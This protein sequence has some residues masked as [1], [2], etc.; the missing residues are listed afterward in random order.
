[1]SKEFTWEEVSRHDKE[2]D[3]WVVIDSYVYDVSSFVE[4]HPG[5]KQ[6]LKN[7]CG[8]D[9]T[10]AYRQFHYPTIMKKYHS[11]LCIGRVK[12]EKSQDEERPIHLIPGSFG[13]MVFYLS[14]RL[15]HLSLFTYF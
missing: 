4:L 12:G 15:P 9:A 11:R 2:G 13:D 8:K 6:V 10:D 5:G 7:A 3:L 14:W 1:M